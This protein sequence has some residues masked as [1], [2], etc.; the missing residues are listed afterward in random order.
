MQINFSLVIEEQMV[1][2]YC[3][4]LF[5]IFGIALILSDTLILPIITLFVCSQEH[6]ILW[7]HYRVFRVT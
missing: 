4:C 2:T 1:Y 3:R 5:D 7:S 6:V